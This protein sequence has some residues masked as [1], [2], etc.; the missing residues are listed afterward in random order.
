MT[1]LILHI[2]HSSDKIPMDKGFVADKKLL[3]Q[4]IIK[5]TDWYTDD[6]FLFEE[7][8]IVQA[9][10]SR[11]F[12]DTERFS[13]DSQE[14]MAEYGMGVL[15]E[16]LDDGSVMREVNPKL[17]E[18]IL[19]N[20][21]WPHHNKLNQAVNDQL[22]SNGRALIVDCHSFPSDPLIRDLSQEENRPDFNIGTDSFHTPN[23]LIEISKY[24]FEERGYSLGIDSPYSGTMVPINHNQKTKN[25]S[26]I[27][28]EINRA[29]YLNEPGNQKSSNY[30]AVKK[31]VNEYLKLLQTVYDKITH[32][33]KISENNKWLF[34][35]DGFGEMEK[36]RT[37]SKD[38]YEKS[39][40]NN[41]DL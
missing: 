21:Y 9:D 31:T 8:I 40:K 38:I 28:L 20:Y 10:F 5:L 12:C 23:D 33:A 29:L 22:I 17:R 25:V 13:D 36:G 14:V 35:T 37:N 2:P 41:T 27:M 6:L 30:L 26:S 7:S 34:P 18:D 4:E 24:F 3:T 16:K 32:R 11:I 19:N 1:N 39:R 15:Y